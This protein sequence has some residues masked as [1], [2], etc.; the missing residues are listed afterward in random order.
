MITN[1]DQIEIFFKEI[2][3]VTEKKI[4]LFVIGGAVL[5]Q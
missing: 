3:K 4:N 1:Y 2:D 5:L